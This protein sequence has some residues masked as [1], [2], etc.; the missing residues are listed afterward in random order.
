MI[1]AYNERKRLVPMLLDALQLLTSGEPLVARQKWAQAPSVGPT[2]LRDALREPLR[3]VEIII[4]DDG[5]SDG[6]AESVLEWARKKQHSFEV[7]GEGN[8]ELRV[9]TLSRNRGKGG[10][11]RHVSVAFW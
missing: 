11:V 1:P 7:L 6:T 9:V 5:S 8:V 4:V 3:N 2:D 10:A